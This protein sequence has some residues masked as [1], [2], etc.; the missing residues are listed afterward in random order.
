MSSAAAAAGSA[1][2]RLSIRSARREGAPSSLQGIS[3]TG[4]YFTRPR[5]TAVTGI[6]G[7]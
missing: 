1:V 5:P 2:P 7:A 4:G 6:P 3:M